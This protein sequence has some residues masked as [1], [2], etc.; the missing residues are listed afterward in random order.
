[1]Y[2]CFVAELH[3]P[4][5][6]HTSSVDENTNMQTHLRDDADGSRLGIGFQFDLE[7]LQTR[8]IL[9]SSYLLIAVPAPASPS[10]IRLLNTWICP[11]CKTDQWAAVEIADGRLTQI[12]SIALT[13]RQLVAANFIGQVDAELL[14]A[15][16][17]GMDSLEFVEQQLD[18]VEV[19]REHLPD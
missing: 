17:V 3:C 12:S 5:C 6:R 1:M 8:R 16:L 4:S 18:P 13:K 10:A 14:A 19:L 9:D 11:A 7:E 2:D 15:A